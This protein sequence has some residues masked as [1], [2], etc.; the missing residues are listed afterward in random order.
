[1]RLLKEVHASLGDEP[2]KLFPAH[3]HFWSGRY[4]S[5]PHTTGWIFLTAYSTAEKLG[6][7]DADTYEYYMRWMIQASKVVEKFAKEEGT[8]CLDAVDKV[9][10]QGL[11]ENRRIYTERDIGVACYG[12]AGPWGDGTWVQAEVLAEEEAVS[13]LKVPK[14]KKK[15][16]KKKSSAAAGVDVVE[17][18]ENKSVGD[19]E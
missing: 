4:T 15:K 8:V 5:L 12:E 3:I 7:V 2:K 10:E 9:R 13:K 17:D 19:P 16:S 6:K 18:A 1:M 14:K 11:G